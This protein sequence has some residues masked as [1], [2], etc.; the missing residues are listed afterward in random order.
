M[1]G[2]P[3]LKG[4]FLVLAAT[5]LTRCASATPIRIDQ[6]ASPPA[7]AL[8]DVSLPDGSECIVRSSGGEIVRGRVV[9]VSADPLQV[10]VSGADGTVSRRSFAHADVAL[11]AKVVKMSKAKRGWVGAAI[12]AAVSVPFGISMVGD[13]VVPAAILGSL[14]G[15]STGDSHAEVVFERPGQ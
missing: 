8:A 11:L 5:L 4:V 13:M 7:R 6:G 10:D 1:R 15:R 2:V 3:V 9:R 14:I 12:G